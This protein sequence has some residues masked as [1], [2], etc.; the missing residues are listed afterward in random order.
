VVAGAAQV[1]A[2]Q[3]AAFLVTMPECYP[4]RDAL[5]NAMQYKVT[6]TGGASGSSGPPAGAQA[7]RTVSFKSPP[8]GNAPGNCTFQAGEAT[9]SGAP[10]N[11]TV[12]NL[13]WP[14]SGDYVLTVTP[15]ADK[16]GHKFDAAR[17]RQ[18]NVKVQ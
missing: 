15:V 3:P 7:T 1:A 16:H 6:W 5:D 11:E 8:L 14:A 13:T 10:K 17:A 12:F 2:G 9:C 4:Y 18:V